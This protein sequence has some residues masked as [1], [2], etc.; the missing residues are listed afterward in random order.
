MQIDRPSHKVRLDNMR[1]RVKPIIVR[2]EATPK[3]A[4]EKRQRPQKPAVRTVAAVKSENMEKNN[5]EE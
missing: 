1:K 5:Q 3:A 4:P 2:T